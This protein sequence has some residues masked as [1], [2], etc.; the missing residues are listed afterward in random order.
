RLV[1]VPDDCGGH[2]PALPTSL[3]RPVA[4]VDILDVE[5]VAGIPAAD[6]LEHFAPHE[7]EGT[8][9]RVDLQRLDCGCVEQVVPPLPAERWKEEAQWSTTDDRAADRGKAPT[10]RL[11]RTV[12]VEHLRAGD[13]AA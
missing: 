11:Q 8:E 10:R 7:E 13:A 2:P 5:L 9:H 12:G 3:H 1:L 6:L 4:E